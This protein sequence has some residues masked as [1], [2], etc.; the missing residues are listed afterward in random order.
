MRRVL[1]GLVLGLTAIAAGPSQ[2]EAQGA[3]AVGTDG[4]IATDGVA[5]GGSYDKS[6]KAEAIATA[7]ADCRTHTDIPKA[8]AQCKIVGTF[9]KACY[10]VA[11]DPKSGTPGAGWAIA[12]NLAAARKQAMANCRATAGASRSKFCQITDIYACDHHN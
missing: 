10:G 3:L 2:L 5:I 11:F 9:S 7:L 8:A 6:T 12:A 1:I 4:D